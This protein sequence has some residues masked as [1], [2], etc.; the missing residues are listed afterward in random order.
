LLSVLAALREIKNTSQIEMIFLKWCGWS[1][2]F[3]LL[4]R[5]WSAKF[6]LLTRDWSEDA[7]KIRQRGTLFTSQHFTTTT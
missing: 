6:I 4:T 7:K 5:D 2:K 1:A 3:I